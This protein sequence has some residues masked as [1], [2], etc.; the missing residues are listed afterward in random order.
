[1]P[2][3]L[4]QIQIMAI[5][6]MNPLKLWLIGSSTCQATAFSHDR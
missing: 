1:M 6:K 2:G 3:P 5:A 4:G